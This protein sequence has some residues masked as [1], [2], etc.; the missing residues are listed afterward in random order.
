[1]VIFKEYYIVSI[2]YNLSFFHIILLSFA[3]Y[4]TTINIIKAIFLNFFLY[5]KL[6]TLQKLQFSQ[7]KLSLLKSIQKIKF[8]PFKMKTPLPIP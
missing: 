1:M 5:T 7:I 8:I 4:T 6:N 3:T 2:I